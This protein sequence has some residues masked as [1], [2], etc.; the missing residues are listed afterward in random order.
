MD[1]ST[2]DFS[3]LD[4]TNLGASVS[5][6]EMLAKVTATGDNIPFELVYRAKPNKAGKKIVLRKNS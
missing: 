6:R 3:S 2:F 4:L 1:D 5:K